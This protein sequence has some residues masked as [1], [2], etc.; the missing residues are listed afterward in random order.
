MTTNELTPVDRRPTK[1]EGIDR[2]A[3]RAG[4]YLEVVIQGVV[5]P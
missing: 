3:R 2:L 1:P 5:T 4:E